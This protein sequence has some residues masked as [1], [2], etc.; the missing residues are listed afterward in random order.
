MSTVY[1]ERI[2]A[3]VQAAGFTCYID[4]T[5]GGI[6]TI[7]AGEPWEEPDGGTRYP[8]LAGP[9]YHRKEGYIGWTGDF[10]VGPDD[11]GTSDAVVI[12]DDWTEQMVI[13]EIIRQLGQKPDEADPP[14]ADPGDREV[15]P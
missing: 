5:G 4:M 13:E 6:F 3:A 11:D 7:R 10:Y 1:L 9:G 2:T 14:G 15:G 8:V 12:T